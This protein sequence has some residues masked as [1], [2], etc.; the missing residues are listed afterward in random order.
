MIICLLKKLYSLWHVYSSSQESRKLYP[1]K[2]SLH[3]KFLFYFLTSFNL[4]VERK[5]Q[6]RKINEGE[7][8][9]KHLNKQ[10]SNVAKPENQ[11]NKPR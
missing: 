2:R 5:I 8:Y 7:S 6:K 1:F 4:Y 11:Q 10:G 3:I 9:V